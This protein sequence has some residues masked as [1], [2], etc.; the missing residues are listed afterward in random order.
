MVCK[1]TR[2]CCGWGW[3]ATRWAWREC[4]PC[5]R[6]SRPTVLCCGWGW[7]ETRLETVEP[8]TSQACCKVSCWHNNNYYGITIT[9][10][11]GAL[12]FFSLIWWWI[13]MTNYYNNYYTGNMCCL[14]SLGLGGNEIHN[15]G[16]AHLALALR[17]NRRLRS[18]GLGGNQIGIIYCCHL[19][20]IYLVFYQHTL[21][22]LLMV[23]LMREEGLLQ[24]C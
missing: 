5:Q 24:R 8:C 20:P 3:V 12:H 11:W 15:E 23:Q 7:G 21:L 16:A 10:H 19:S 14:Q 1:P 18:L 17:T 13:Q 9:W 22:Y 6:L 4:G 2:A